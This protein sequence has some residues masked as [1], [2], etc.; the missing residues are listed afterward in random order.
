M[1]KIG[2]G[3]AVLIAVLALLSGCLPIG[4]TPDGAQGG[5]DWTLI[6]F[7]VVIFVVFYFLMIR[8]QR[9]RQK[10]Q[11][12]MLGGLQRGDKIVTA[13][14]IYGEIESIDE[15]S[16]VMKVESGATMRIAKGSVLGKQMQ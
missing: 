4:Q 1:F 6:V 10:E 8:P 7:L 15:R 3:V 2:L 11:E 16:I 13:G 9:R 14:G 5:F 12:N